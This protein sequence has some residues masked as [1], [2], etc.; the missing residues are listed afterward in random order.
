MNDLPRW[1]QALLLIVFIMLAFFALYLLLNAIQANASTQ[2]VACEG[3]DCQPT[4]TPTPTPFHFSCNEEKQCVKVN[5]K[6]QS[7]CESKWDCRH[8]KDCDGDFDKSDEKEC[9]TP[10]PTTTA[11]PS[12]TPI[13]T[14]TPSTGTGDGKSD[15]R[16][17]DPG[18]TQAHNPTCTVP[19]TPPILNGFKANGNGSVTF[20]WLESAS[21]ITKYSIV[22]GYSADEM[23]MGMDNI[24]SSST[25]VTL[26]GL[27]EGVNVFAQVYAWHNQCAEISNVFDPIVK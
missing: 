5:G 9:L 25:S 11:T 20:S 18:A 14:S 6:G 27:H 2:I 4:A 16:S 12:A 8:V 24:P 10:A 26:N 21:N 13:P 19:F 23:D 1:K 3:K 22:F 17:S 7:T 15:G